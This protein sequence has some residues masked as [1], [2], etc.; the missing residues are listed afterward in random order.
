METT[1][2]LPRSGRYFPAAVRRR[3]SARCRASL[4]PIETRVDTAGRSTRSRSPKAYRARRGRIVWDRLHPNRRR[5]R[6]REGPNLTPGRGVD[7][8]D[9]FKKNA[10]AATG[11]AAVTAAAGKRGG[12]LTTDDRPEDA[13]DE[14]LDSTSDLRLSGQYCSPTP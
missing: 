12:P 3:E 10:R 1:A 7:F 4:Q 9:G 6:G 14:S 8:A 5:P 13:Q 2:E 11:G